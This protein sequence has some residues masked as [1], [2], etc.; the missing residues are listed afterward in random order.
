[1]KFHDLGEVGAQG[2]R[3]EAAGFGQYLVQIVRPECKF[4][5]LG[6]DCLLPKPRIM[7]RFV[8]TAQDAVPFRSGLTSRMESGRSVNLI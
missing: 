1:L 4:S 6:P 7:H 5:K 8:R 3:H 2:L